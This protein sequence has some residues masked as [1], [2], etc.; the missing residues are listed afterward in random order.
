MQH[1]PVHPKIAEVR[2]NLYKWFFKQ[3]SR[4]ENAQAVLICSTKCRYL[5]MKLCK[6][7]IK[8]DDTYQEIRLK[9]ISVVVDV[10]ELKK[11]DVLSAYEK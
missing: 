8:P 5:F 3:R 10:S 7:L 9:P 11:S 4:D 6:E 1:L 2:N